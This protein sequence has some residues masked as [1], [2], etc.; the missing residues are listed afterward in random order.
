M[1]ENG[2]RY[3]LMGRGLAG[4]PIRS[5]RD[6]SIEWEK[7]HPELVYRHYM[8]DGVLPVDYWNIPIIN[9]SSAERI[10][11]P[12]QKPEELLEKIILNARIYLCI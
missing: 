8:K 12:T 3:R 6:V 2:N 9:Q 5:K 11:Y 1:D 10:G 7:T 4:S